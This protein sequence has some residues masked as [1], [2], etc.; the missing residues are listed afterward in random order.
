MRTIPFLILTLL[1]LSSC[2]FALPNAS[3]GSTHSSALIEE[4]SGPTL[5]SFDYGADYIDAH[6]PSSYWITY[7]F[8]TKTNG[9]ADEPILITSARNEQGYYIKDNAGTE[10]LFLK[11]GSSYLVYMP[12][13]AGELALVPDLRLDEENVKGYSTSFLGF[14]GIYDVAKDDLVP[15]GEETVAGRACSRYVFHANYVASA[16]DLYYSIDKATG[17]CL[18]YNAQAL[19]GNDTSAFEF[20]CTVFKDANVTLPA[21]I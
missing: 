13:D 12:N 2:T 15:A 21:H 3:N 18:R 17:I 10:A 20:L 4:D 14:M 11:D 7:S 5:S 16:I 8:S 19:Q 1:S 6:L 9:V